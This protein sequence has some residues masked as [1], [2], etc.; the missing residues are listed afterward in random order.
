[1]VT[2]SNSEILIE[3]YP[4]LYHMAHAGAWPSIER[5]GL[6]STSALLDL[7]EIMGARRVQLESCRRGK[8]EEI[9][10]PTHG[11][12]LLRDQIPLNEK[13]LANALLDGLTP[14]DWYK[15]LNRKVFFWGPQSRL[16]TLQGAR[17]YSEHRQT[18]VVIDTAQLVA[19][20]QGQILLCHMNSGA[21]NPMA[22]ARGLNTF[23]PIDEYPLVERR[24]KYGIKGAVAEITVDYSVPDVSEYVTEAYEIGGGEP[25]R[26]L[27][28]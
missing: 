28:T 4:R 19:R 10:H 22:F 14:R 23:L 8:S 11:R 9:S 7:F 6:M 17:A 12:A 2:V 15:I 27:L 3:T 5:L 13:K 1:M 21:S 18:I 16:G 25:R 24:R 20:H 26:D